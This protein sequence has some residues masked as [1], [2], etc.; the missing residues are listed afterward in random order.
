[1]KSDPSI[2]QGIRIGIHGYESENSKNPS[3]I[4]GVF[5]IERE[6]IGHLNLGSYSLFPLSKTAD[7][8]QIIICDAK[9]NR[10]LGSLT[11]MLYE[12]YS[13]TT[14][15]GK[16]WVTLFD[17][18]DDDVYDGDYVE[19]DIEV[20][21]AL[22][23]YEVMKVQEQLNETQGNDRVIFESQSKVDEQN[24]RFD[25]SEIISNKEGKE[26]KSAIV[27]TE[28]EETKIKEK[29]IVHSQDDS[30]E[31]P[32]FF[33]QLEE[34]VEKSQTSYEYNMKVIEESKIEKNGVV[35][36]EYKTYTK[37][38]K[39]NNK[40]DDEKRAR[41]EEVS[42]DEGYKNLQEKTNYSSSAANNKQTTKEDVKVE[43]QFNT[44]IQT[45]EDQDSIKI[46]DI[47]N[48][49]H[50]TILEDS[51]KEALKRQIRTLIEENERLQKEL[52]DLDNKRKDFFIKYQAEIKDYDERISNFIK[53]KYDFQQKIASQ[54][55]TLEEINRKLKNTT[56]EL[57][58]LQETTKR[59]LEAKNAELRTRIAA[60]ETTAR[61]SSVEITR[62]S[63]EK[64]NLQEYIDRLVE[65]EKKYLGQ[66]KE[67]QEKL[68]DCEN[69]R[70]EM[71]SE[72]RMKKSNEEELKERIRILEQEN[73]ALKETCE[74]LQNLLKNIKGQMVQ[75]EK[76]LIEVE[77]KSNRELGALHQKN[78]ELTSLVEQLKARLE[79]Y[80]NN[81]DNYENIIKDKDEEI[82]ELKEV[83]EELKSKLRTQADSFRNEF[84]VKS[85]LWESE[86]NSLKKC[87]EEY[88]SEMESLRRRLKETED[89]LLKKV[90]LEEELKEKVKFISSLEAI[91][92][93]EKT[94]NEALK[95]KI[96]KLEE[97]LN[98]VKREAKEMKDQYTELQKRATIYEEKIKKITIELNVTTNKLKEKES[99]IKHKENKS[100]EN[101][102]EIEAL[103]EKL[104]ESDARVAEL[105]NE[106]KKWNERLDDMA[107]KAK[108]IESWR[109]RSK[110][111]DEKLQEISIKLIQ[112]N[113]L[114][115]EFEIQLGKMQ[116][117]LNKAKNDLGTTATENEELRRELA[118]RNKEIE[119]LNSLLAN[120]KQSE[121]EDSKL[122]QGLYTSDKS[123]K[124]DQ[125]FALYIN[126]VRCPV[127]LKR[128]G[129]G[130]Y[131]FGTKKIFAKIQNEKLVIRVGGGYMMIEDFLTTYTAQE[132]SKMKRNERNAANEAELDLSSNGSYKA[133]N[134]YSKLP[135]KEEII[136]ED[137]EYDQ[138]PVSAPRSKNDHVVFTRST[139]KAMG[140]KARVPSG[141][142]NRSKS[143]SIGLINGS[144]RARVLTEQ[145]LSNAKI[146]KMTV[147]KVEAKVTTKKF[148]PGEL[149]YVESENDT[150]GISK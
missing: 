71:A 22:I 118:Q 93:E 51:E 108:D 87:L 21:R 25:M 17:D 114:S 110:N 111:K 43:L 1:M 150:S 45:K 60:Y 42:V 105:E 23:S 33:S 73:R 18:P 9:T 144:N 38:S 4:Y 100:K 35:I 126:A 76:K 10:S 59:Q 34:E 3:A 67:V 8:F 37:E 54:E 56:N 46:K 131:I 15:Q 141:I 147:D 117:E 70:L 135:G 85:Q 91:I 48:E 47:I 32:G 120:C 99:D 134:T 128:I 80:K 121:P 52:Q 72:I 2:N 29:K 103:K 20:P 133:L 26:D 112:Q 113:K 55:Y 75:L 50:K 63:V 142:T 97:E 88:V 65:L 139:S 84:S 137:T 130:Q 49:E 145:D 57:N 40:S 44:N 6:K 36:K 92:N 28:S 68:I 82:K 41:T 115:R 101:Q 127:K 96:A 77:Q 81:S 24:E 104:K 94:S 19:D 39:S 148:V 27:I 14:Q 123:D 58:N 136:E 62:K 90:Q 83:N 86:K 69:Q 119:N 149:K 138:V 122:T 106:Q 30:I 79:E 5:N 53:E 143:P 13:L 129:E 140:D 12:I 64:L 124:I 11:M 16:H 61:D 89:E 98:K 132:L 31:I 116:D 74:H 107:Q 109:L 78:I 102:N 146:T 66:L 7:T 95:K 125:M